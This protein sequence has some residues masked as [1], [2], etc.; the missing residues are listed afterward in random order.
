CHVAAE[1][2]EDELADVVE[3]DTTFLDGRADRDESII[4]EYDGSR[5]LCHI[6]APD[7]HRHTDIRLLQGGCIV[8]AVAE[9]RDDLAPLLKSLHDPQLVLGADA[10]QY[11]NAA[12]PL[13]EFS[14]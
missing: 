8:D 11:R 9:H 2:I 10:A 4:L 13:A 7:S 5:F 3:D 1:Q 12:Q 14:R 6:G